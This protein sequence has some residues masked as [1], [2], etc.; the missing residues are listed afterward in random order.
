MI[1]I[2]DILGPL[3]HDRLK[4][5]SSPQNLKIRG[6]ETSF[7]RFK[8][9]L[10]STSGRES[11]KAI[12]IRPGSFGSDKI[13][14]GLLWHA[15]FGKKFKVLHWFVLFHVLTRTL[16]KDKNSE[17]ILAILMIMTADAATS[18]WMSNM[19][20]LR[21]IL[22]SHLGHERGL[23]FLEE[24]MS[25]LPYRLPKKGPVI[26]EILSFQKAQIRQRKPKEL[27]RIGV[28]YKDKGSLGGSRV[29]S[30]DSEE[31]EEKDN[32]FVDLVRQV[33]GKCPPVLLREL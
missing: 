21:G 15:L 19:K 33:R 29:E 16:K 24:L 27:A 23:A 9:P 22:I 14:V 28:G 8:V 17:A 1:S 32:V 3:E 26:D 30:F 4:I 6:L 12:V 31:F 2:A 20:P 18:N 13:V 11:Y 10:E 25:N 5:L 7:F